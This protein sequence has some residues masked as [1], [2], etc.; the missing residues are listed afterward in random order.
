MQ[1]RAQYNRVVQGIDEHE[2]IQVNIALSYFESEARDYD[3]GNMVEFYNDD[4]FN[5]LYKMEVN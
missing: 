4:S 3:R 1:N 2:K 5:K